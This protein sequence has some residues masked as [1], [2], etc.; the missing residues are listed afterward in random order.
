MSFLTSPNCQKMP[1]NSFLGEGGEGILLGL[2]FDYS[3]VDQA[4][5]ITLCTN[6]FRFLVIWRVKC[7][8]SYFKSFNNI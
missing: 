7:V 6:R 5:S 8:R 1:S 4:E 2:S 3:L